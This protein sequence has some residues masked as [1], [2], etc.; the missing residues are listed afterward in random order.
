MADSQ[1]TALITGITG[2]DGAYLARTLLDDGYRVHGTSRRRETA[3]TSRLAAVGALDDVELFSLN[4][5]DLDSVAGLLESEAYTHVFH[6][7]APSSVAQSFKDP[8]ATINSIVIGTHNLVQAVEKTR[9]E[10]ILVNTSSSESFGTVSAPADETCPFLPRSPYGIAKATTHWLVD[11]GRLRGHRF[12][13]AILFNHESPLRP[14]AFVTRK[15]VLG[16]IKVHNKEID[17]LDLG[18]LD[19]VRD[20]GWAPEYVQA[21]RSIA[22]CDEPNDFV[23]ATGE[24]MEL[25]DFVATAFGCFGL[26]WKNHVRTAE[27]LLRPADIGYSVGDP[28]RIRQRLGW[29]AECR[30]RRLVERLV[31]AELRTAR[32]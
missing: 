26:D 17:H 10:A 12:S 2:Q 16:A 25:T 30:G 6:F 18:N 7:A 9:P 22:E 14:E 13:S 32:R 24:G 1:K 15:I 3:D 20:W 28:G 5:D 4:L 29:T 21:I 27:E 8:A 23:I 19:V 31:E 11:Q